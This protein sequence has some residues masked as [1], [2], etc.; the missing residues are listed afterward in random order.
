[1]R[2]GDRET[3]LMNTLPAKKLKRSRSPVRPTT[4]FLSHSSSPTRPV[5]CEATELVVVGKKTFVFLEESL[6]STCTDRVR[7][8]CAAFRSAQAWINIEALNRF[9]DS[10]NTEEVDNFASSSDGLATNRFEKE[11]AFPTLVDEAGFL[12]IAHGLDFGSGH[13]PLLHT[14]RNGAG[15]WL[16][17]R[18]GLVQMGQSNPEFSAQWLSSLTVEDIQ[19]FFDLAPTSSAKEAL[20]LLAQQLLVSVHEFGNRLTALGHSTPGQY[21]ATKA[22]EVHFSA[23]ALVQCLVEDFPCTFADE[24]DLCTEAMDDRNVARGRNQQV[25]FYKKAQLV[26][27]EIHLRFLEESS[28]PRFVFHDIDTLTA[29]VDNVVVAM[30][31]M[32]GIVQCT[33]QLA[34][35]IA[36]EE[37]LTRG[38]EAEVALRAASLHAVELLVQR[39]NMNHSSIGGEGGEEGDRKRPRSL[40]AQRLCNWLWGCLGKRGPNRSF[41]RHLTPSTSF[42]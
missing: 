26:V 34:E 29:F 13:R 42:Y 28:T 5:S 10:I 33:E 3:L 20:L 21:I 23:T 35:S 16:T 9:A 37:P 14:H 4:T 6:M 24:Y 1:M 39:I 17:I 36:R 32:T 7:L 18:A 15:A 40:N 11:I 19:R 38:S 2:S 41:P 31:R 12:L 25:C 27:S 8:S 30:M 22:K